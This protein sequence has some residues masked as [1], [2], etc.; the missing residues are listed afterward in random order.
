M[1]P[2]EYLLIR[3]DG[4]YAYCKGSTKKIKMFC[5]LRGHCCRQKQKKAADCIMR[6][7]VIQL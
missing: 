3:I 6:I 4:D 1:G 5:R 2:Y 7:F